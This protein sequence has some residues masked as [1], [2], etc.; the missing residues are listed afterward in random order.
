[1]INQLKTGKNS[2]QIG[3]I[4]SHL[5]IVRGHSRKGGKVNSIEVHYDHASLEHILNET[6]TMPGIVDVRVETAEG[7]L[8]VGD[9][10]L[11]V[12]VA[13]DIREHVFPAL[14]RL[15][16]RIKDEAVSKKEF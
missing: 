5:G 16:D 13:G 14:I 4:A 10:I 1:M 8:K 12:A 3:M 7:L 11:A 9:E 6:K 15:V 2:M